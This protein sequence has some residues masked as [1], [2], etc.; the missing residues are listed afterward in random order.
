MNTAKCHIPQVDLSETRGR[1]NRV[2]SVQINT[3]HNSLT[4]DIHCTLFVHGISE[5]TEGEP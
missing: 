3:H 2:V 1:E 5:C 4:T